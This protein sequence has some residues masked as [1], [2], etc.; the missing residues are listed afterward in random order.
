VLIV[1]RRMKRKSRILTDSSRED[2]VSMILGLIIVGV[3]IGLI[4]NYIQRRRGSISV[5]GVSNQVS[6]TDDITLA[7][8][9]T[10]I[11]NGL[12]MR[13]Y[14]VKKGDNLWDISVK[15][16]GNGYKW[17]DIAKRNN[18]ANANFLVVEQELILPFSEVVPKPS[19]EYI[20]KRGDSLWKISVDLYSD[21][22]K[23]TDIWNQN[24]ELIPNPDL[25][26]TGTKLALP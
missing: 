3:V 15:N 9:E 7:P 19:G 21:G 25:I 16:Y 4:F 8:T 23:W 22:F 20:V 5:P 10:E 12:E 13:V 11:K 1:S 26:E 14:K 18:I 17:V 6:L 24:K 2:L